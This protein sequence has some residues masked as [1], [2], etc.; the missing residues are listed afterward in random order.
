MYFFL[1][2]V[3]SLSFFYR[4]KIEFNLLEVQKEKKY[5]VL[6]H[7]FL[8]F[9]YNFVTLFLIWNFSEELDRF[10]VTFHNLFTTYSGNYFHFILSIFI[11]KEGQMPVHKKYKKKDRLALQFFYICSLVNTSLILVLI[12]ACNMGGLGFGAI[13]LHF[14]VFV[15]KYSMVILLNSYIYVHLVILSFLLK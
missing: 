2:L 12:A 15:E 6:F 7:F 13:I 10:N 9:S 4:K 11:E 3:F 8:F 1:L 14:C 5:K